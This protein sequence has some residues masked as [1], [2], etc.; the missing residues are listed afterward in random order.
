MNLRWSSLVTFQLL[1]HSSRINVK[2]VELISFI[3]F[4][5]QSLV[6]Q[7]HVFLI[8]LSCANRLIYIF[9]SSSTVNKILK[10]QKLFVPLF[11]ADKIESF[12]M[13]K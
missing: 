4:R 9:V 5:F 6:T 3:W 11:L 7:S 2:N 12:A 8:N 1:N 10:N 13:G